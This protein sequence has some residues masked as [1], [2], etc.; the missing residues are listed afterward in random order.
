MGSSNQLFTQL[1]GIWAVSCPRTV[2]SAVDIL[3]AVCALQWHVLLHFFLCLA[4][5]PRSELLHDYH[6]LYALLGR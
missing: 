3:L 5:L 1:L 2:H 6:A 4:S